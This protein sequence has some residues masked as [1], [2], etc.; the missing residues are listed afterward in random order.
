MDEFCAPYASVIDIDKAKLPIAEEV[1]R[2]DERAIHRRAA[3]RSEASAL[4]RELQAAPA[5][6]LQT[7]GE[8][9]VSRYSDLLV[10]NEEVVGKNVT[11]NLYARHLRPLFVD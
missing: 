7:R 4:Q 2:L 5:R 1:R 9:P 3:S 11:E 10:A 8:K 6:L